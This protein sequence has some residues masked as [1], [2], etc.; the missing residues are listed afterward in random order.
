MV[1]LLSLTS[2]RFVRFNCVV[3]PQNWLATTNQFFTVLYLV[4]AP[5]SLESRGSMSVV[6]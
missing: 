2:P 5:L 1:Y 4:T 6:G 3:I